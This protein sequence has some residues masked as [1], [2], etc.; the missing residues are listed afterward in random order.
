MIVGVVGFIGSGKGTVG[1]FLKT[2]FGFHSLSFASHLK[3]V[4]SVLFGWERH[5]LEGDTE[6]SRKFR[7]KPDGFWS[8]KIGE[9]FTPRL[10]LQLL[11]TEAGRNVFHEDF[12]IFSLENKIKKLGDNQNV[13]VTD[14]RFKNEIEWL[15]SKKG[16]LIEVRRGE[17]PSWFH[18]AADANRSNGSAFSEKFMLEK[19]GVHESEWR[20]I[21]SGVD[22]IIDNN[23]TL[24]K[25][26]GRI[27]DCLKGHYGS[28]IIESLK[29]RSL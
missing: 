11:G 13:V 20:W 27:T 12:W 15:K 26:K 2:E 19:T 24:E 10:A 22:Y 28:D 18:I 3:D 4:A 9:H 29:Q 17:R 21:G 14:V 5:L 8:K 16:I 1:D 6:E 7:E 23:D 25:L